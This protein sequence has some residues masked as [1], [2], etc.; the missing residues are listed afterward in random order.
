MKFFEIMP[1]CI[2]RLDTIR[3]AQLS[4]SDIEITYTCGDTRTEQFTFSCATAATDAF[5][6]LCDALK[7]NEEVVIY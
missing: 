7:V 2:I 1:D 5:E 3:T 6:K 4:H